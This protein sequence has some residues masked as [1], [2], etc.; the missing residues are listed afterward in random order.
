[1]IQEIIKAKVVVRLVH[2]WTRYFTAQK[3]Q[4]S[5]YARS[6]RLFISIVAVCLN[7]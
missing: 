2:R 6:V 3:S 5:F 4:S 7:K 1:M